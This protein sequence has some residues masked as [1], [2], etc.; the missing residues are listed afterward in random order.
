MNSKVLAE[1]F[2]PT[3]AEIAAPLALADTPHAALK[4]P[5]FGP[6]NQVSAA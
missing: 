1:K 3:K 5:A 2:G 4:C 6:E